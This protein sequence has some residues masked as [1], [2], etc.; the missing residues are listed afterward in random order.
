MRSARQKVKLAKYLV[1]ARLRLPTGMNSEQ[2]FQSVWQWINRFKWVDRALQ[3]YRN[4]FKHP[5]REITFRMVLREMDRSGR[6]YKPRLLVEGLEELRACLDEGR[7]TVVTTLHSPLVEALP[8][9]YEELDLPTTTIVDHPER[10]QRNARIIGMK[11]RIDHVK[12]APDCL[13]L[14]S[15]KLKS[16]GLVSNCVDFVD[17]ERREGSGVFISPAMFDF[18]KRTSSAIVYAKVTLTDEA[19]I[20]IRF[21]KSMPNPAKS[22]AEDLAE[23][24]IRWL[25]HD[26]RDPRQFSVREHVQDQAAQ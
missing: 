9:L 23:D 25:V 11:G 12:L 22:S 2:R 17:P 6:P 15:R 14:L 7:P 24:F 3:A 26:Q 10:V 4:N 5:T 16:G 20:K 18:A 1:R 13:F 21:A 19:A 8:R